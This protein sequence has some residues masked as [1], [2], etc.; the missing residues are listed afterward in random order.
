MKTRQFARLALGAAFPVGFIWLIAR[1]IHLD[2]VLRVFQQVRW[3]WFLMALFA[4]CAGY[5]FRIQRWKHMLMQDNPSVSWRACAGPL[6]GS[7]AVNNVLPFRAGDVLRSFAFNRELGVS[8]AV[9]MATLL[10]ERLLDLL[11]LFVVLGIALALF[12]LNLSQLSG[13]GASF[14]V[15]AAVGILAVLLFP[16][17]FI[18]LVGWCGGL[19]ARFFPGIGG[20]VREAGLKVLATL[21][22]LSRGHTMSLLLLWSAAAWLSEGCVFWFAAMALPPL[23][24]PSA[25]WLALPIGTLATL[26]PSTPGYVGTFDFFTVKAMTVVG[27][28]LAAATAYAFLV[29]ALL[30][31]PVTLI[32]GAYMLLRSLRRTSTFQV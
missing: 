19:L 11:L 26:I 2:E 3:N 12:G 5:V 8:T 6:L 22:H 24:E 17:L 1:Q 7:F 30:W 25:G 18:P 15:L 13:V 32:G 4:F 20:R 27:N 23:V 16:S 31:F 14:L 28:Q 9:V 29:H 21:T 10:V